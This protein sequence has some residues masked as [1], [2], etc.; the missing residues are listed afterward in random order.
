[1]I[2]D[3]LKYDAQSLQQLLRRKLLQGGVYTDQMYP[4]SDTKIVLDLFAWTF[5][6]LTYILN[7]NAADSLFADT[8][9]Y[10]NMNRL[11]KLLSYNPDGYHSANC[12]FRLAINNSAIR[13]GTSLLPDICTIPK[14]ASIDIGKT[15]EKGNQVKYSFIEDYTFSINNTTTN[16]NIISPDYW[17]LLVNGEFKKYSTVFTSTGAPYESFLLSQLNPKNG[18]YVDHDN[19]H[20]YIE[21]INEEDGS[22]SYKEWRQVSNLVLDSSY[23]SEDCEL[24]LNENKIYTLSFGDNIHG[25]S[26]NYGDKIHIIYLLSNV[27]DGKIQNG[28]VSVTSMD[29][30]I[31]G[32]ANSMLMYDLCYGGIEKFKTKYKGIFVEN[33]VVKNNCAKI[34]LINL[35]QSSEPKA[36]ESVQSIR[37]NAPGM[38]RMGNRLV[39]IDDYKNYIMAIYSH[40]VRDVWVCNN[41]SYITT[42]YGWLSKYNALSVNIRKYNYLYSDTCD[43]NNIYLW[44]KSNTRTNLT[45]NDMNSI[46]KKCANIKSATVEVVPCNAIVKYFT[47]FVQ[48]KDYPLTYSDILFEN[49]NPNIRIRVTKKPGTYFSNVQIIEDVTTK[50]LDYFSI[51]NQEMG[52]TVNI[53]QLYADIMKLGY[54][55]SIKTVNIPSDNPNNEYWINGLS[56]ACFS[57][58]IINGAD[59]NT[60]NFSDQLQPFQFASLYNQN[61]IKSL[62][63]I[64]NKD[65]LSLL[66]TG[67]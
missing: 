36:A 33:N 65:T 54:I 50:I 61:V 52:K 64:E 29:L 28:E 13:S 19:F 44:M 5:D 60:V 10:E 34:Q 11:V 41:N 51:A 24:R 14:F 35:T 67:F 57:L 20:I 26:L 39:T 46:I 45:Q 42:F 12:T 32:F 9:V 49:W 2:Y 16:S 40:L 62:I 37:Q 6:V 47:P 21:S 18:I 59:F 3:Y 4:G 56:F 38:F 66:N 63:Q 48:H 23:N 1:M 8:Q 30:N 7:N 15:D 43:F 31:P 22:T 17:P 58:D 53:D 27:E 55:E 25:K